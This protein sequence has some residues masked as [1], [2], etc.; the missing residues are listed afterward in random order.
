MMVS[1]NQTDKLWYVGQT[2]SGSFTIAHVLKHPNYTEYQVSRQGWPD[3]LLI[4]SPHGHLLPQHTQQQSFR[5]KIHSWITLGLHPHIEACYASVPGGDSAYFL[6][7]IYGQSLRQWISGG[8]WSLRG[9]LSLGLQLCH[10]LEYL[11][12][13]N[14]YLPQFS[15]GS[16]WVTAHSLLKIRDIF[17]PEH[18]TTG[19]IGN[20]TGKQKDIHGV[21][22]VL[23]ELLCDLAYAADDIRSMG[24]SHFKA[25]ASR[26]DHLLS[27]I[28]KGCLSDEPGRQ[29]KNISSIRHAINHA[30]EQIFGIDC[31]Y[32]HL[33]STELKAPANNNHAVFLFEEGRFK[34]GLQK[35]HEALHLQDRQPEAIYNL[36]VYKLRSGH[37]HPQKI[38]LMIQA[39]HWHSSLKTHLEYLQSL[40]RKIIKGDALQKVVP[41]PFL[42]CRSP[43]ALSFY[44]FQKYHVEKVNVVESHLTKL[45]YEASH[46]CLLNAWRKKNFEKDTLLAK[47]YDQLLTKSDKKEIVAVQRFATIMGSDRP[48]EHLAYVSGTRR[49][50]E[51]RGED[52]VLL[53]HYGKDSKV[54]TLS[55]NGDRVC[56]LAVSPNG[57]IIA[58]AAESGTLFLW[59]I[60]I[61]KKTT[62]NPAHRARI[63]SLNFSDDGRFLA[64]GRVD[65]MLVIRTVSTGREKFVPVWENQQIRQ[66]AFFPGSFDLVI[67][68]NHGEI[69]LWASRGRKCLHAL[70]AHNGPVVGL[71]VAPSGDFFATS[72]KKHIKIWDRYSGECLQEIPGHLGA[73][74]ALLLLDDNRHLVSAGLDDMIKIWDMVSGDMVQLLDGRGKGICC[75]AKGSK[76]HFFFGGGRKGDMIIWKII[77]NLEF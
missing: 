41:P 68:G 23:C 36:I 25:S 18:V 59:Q 9:A 3:T 19:N 43:Q 10:G 61:N 1:T 28:I 11:H 58:A 76:Q 54:V 66:V 26:Y 22:E 46:S 67:A 8:S 73:T 4:K 7:H 63:N 5:E 47:M 40:V 29:F 17:L 35:L 56:G 13:R 14:I 38:D 37:Y 2:I 21:G 24:Q 71:T 69:Q 62:N 31:P 15:T 65:G 49:I 52:K 34:E 72:G 32:H 6:E 27:P 60:G 16:I 57:K 50:A 77:Y 75:L 53:R 55:T 70:N 12:Q 64:N 33:H 20:K 74:T 30:Y 44:R 45:R 39:A 51:S 48:L 42:L